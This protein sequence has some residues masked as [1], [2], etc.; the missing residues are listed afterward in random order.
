MQKNNL[1]GFEN[2]KNKKEQ[3]L[4]TKSRILLLIVVFIVFSMPLLYLKFAYLLK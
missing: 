4:F 2:M 3:N 1:P